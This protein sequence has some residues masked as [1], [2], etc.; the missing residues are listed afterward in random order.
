MQVTN[1]RR[2]APRSPSRVPCDIYDAKGHAIVAEA[3]CVDFS[4]LGARMVSR[5][6]FKPKSAIRFQLVPS[7]KPVLDLAGR[8][9]WAKKKSKGFEYGICFNSQPLAPLS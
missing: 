7:D 2:R 1:E 9:V 6:P 3:R 5:K 8:V 4:V